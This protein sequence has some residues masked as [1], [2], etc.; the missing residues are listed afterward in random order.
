MCRHVKCLLFYHLFC[1]LSDTP[2][3]ACHLVL[4]CFLLIPISTYSL[5]TLINVPSL[6]SSDKVSVQ[7]HKRKTENRN[8]DRHIKYMCFCSFGLLLF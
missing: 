2:G 3:K 8:E 1:C 6:H 4:F 7:R 5:G